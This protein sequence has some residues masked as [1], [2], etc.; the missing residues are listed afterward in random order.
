MSYL[1]AVHLD[2]TYP[3]KPASQTPAVNSPNGELNA[4]LDLLRRTLVDNS[5]H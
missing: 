5:S 4:H 1:P 2:V 3:V